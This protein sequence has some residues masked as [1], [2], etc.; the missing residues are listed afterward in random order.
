MDA[1]GHRRSLLLDH[2][3]L[4]HPPFHT[5]VETGPKTADRLYRSHILVLLHPVPRPV[6]RR[7]PV[8]VHGV[9]LLLRLA[10]GHLEDHLHVV[11]RAA[12]SNPSMQVSSENDQGSAGDKSNGGQKNFH[13]L[14]V[15]M[16]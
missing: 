3:A 12:A 16:K 2:T 13:L 9:P 10:G 15:D 6:D 1:S 11:R 7:L 4:A 8:V 5:L 14:E